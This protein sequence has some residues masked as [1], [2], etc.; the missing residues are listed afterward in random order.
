[1]KRIYKYELGIE[2]RAIIKLELPL[3]NNILKW[4]MQSRIICFWALVDVSNDLTTTREFRIIA[5]GQVIE[6]KEKYLA[7][8]FDGPFVWHIIEL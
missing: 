1:M 2:S 8:V 3:N 6:Q 5:T 7:T 4:A